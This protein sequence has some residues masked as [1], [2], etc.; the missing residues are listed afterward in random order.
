MGQ[1]AIGNQDIKFAKGYLFGTEPGGLADDVPF[2]ELQ[3][4]TVKFTQSLKEMMGPESLVAVA[5]GVSEKKVTVT[6]KFGKIRARQFNMFAGGAAPTNSG[7][8]TT[9]NFGVNDQPRQFN[10]H[11]LSPFDGSDVELKIYGCISTDFSLPFK[12]NDFVIPDFTANAYGDGTNIM[13]FISPGNQ[14]TS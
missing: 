7:G 14:T 8:F 12:L 13:T 3:E 9:T 11:L 4:I 6:A 2:G 1:T 5:V 10:L